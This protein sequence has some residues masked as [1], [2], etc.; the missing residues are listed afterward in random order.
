VEQF[1]SDS[2]ILASGHSPSFISPENLP[3]HS[4]CEDLHIPTPKYTPILVSHQHRMVHT[5]LSHP[6]PAEL[7]AFGITILHTPGHTPDELALWD[8]K[9]HI[10]YVGDTLYE[11]APIIFPS[12]GSIVEWLRSVDALLEVAG[13]I[14]DAKVCCGHVTYGRPARDVL[15]TSKQFINDVI[16]GKE[17]VRKKFEKRGE[18]TVQYVQDGLRYSLVCPERLVLEARELA[19][20][21]GSIVLP[22]LE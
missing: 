2:P 22:S 9:E 15:E 19:N 10:L 12:E 20:S 16:L 7:G 5:T 17:I 18:V 11:W 13:R 21:T 6:G 8:E 14:E 4:I 1:A 3:K